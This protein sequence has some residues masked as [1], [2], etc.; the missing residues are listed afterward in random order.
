VVTAEESREMF[1]DK[2]VEL[3][4]DSDDYAAE[5]LDHLMFL[6]VDRSLTT[7]ASREKDVLILPVRE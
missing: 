2:P 1:D 7:G 3:R 6:C 4:L 5:D